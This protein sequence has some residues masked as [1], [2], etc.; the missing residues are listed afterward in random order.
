MIRCMIKRCVL[1]LLPLFLIACNGEPNSI[2][3]DKLPL[4]SSNE[5]EQLLLK[6][7]ASLSKWILKQQKKYDSTHSYIFKNTLAKDLYKNSYKHFPYTK[8]LI[9]RDDVDL[10]VKKL[11]LRFSQCLNL[12]DYLLL[13]KV[14]IDVG[15]VDLMSVF[16][17]PGPEY[18]V[19]L[20]ENYLAPSV[21]VFLEMVVSKYPSIDGSVDLI[22][23]GSNF[24]QTTEYRKAGELHPVLSCSA[25]D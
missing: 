23:S 25:S 2:V 7:T 20:D 22:K 16:I 4:L 21:I 1:F 12:K 19:I 3:S 14:I 9:V 24:R 8:R 18:G 10:E 5:A 17:S 6:E 15:D 11:L 13:G